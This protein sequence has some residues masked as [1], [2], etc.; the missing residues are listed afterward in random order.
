MAFVCLNEIEIQGGTVEERRRA[1]ALVLAIDCVNEGAASQRETEARLSLRLE[2][3]D[4]LPEE[5]LSSLASQF[6]DLSFTLVY[7]SLDGEFFGYARMGAAGEAAESADFSEDTR[8]IVGRRYD[9]DG[10]AFV[11]ASYSLARAGD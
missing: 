1:A 5:E 11:R 7:F 8:D 2:S 6:P 3:V 4:G 10:L 9:G